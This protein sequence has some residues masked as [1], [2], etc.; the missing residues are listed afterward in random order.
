MVVR[1]S[2]L[3][4]TGLQ[5]GRTLLLQRLKVFSL[6]VVLRSKAIK[7]KLQVKLIAKPAFFVSILRANA[8]R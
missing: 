3:M 2:G 5:L 8:S 6:P 7:R 4:E 1:A